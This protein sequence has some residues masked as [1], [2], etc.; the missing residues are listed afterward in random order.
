MTEEQAAQIIKE[1]E[2]IR[3]LKLAEMLERGYSQSQLAQILGVSQPTI[4]RM[5][6]KVTGKKG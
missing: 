2:I 3:K 1:L 6:P 4:S 5:A